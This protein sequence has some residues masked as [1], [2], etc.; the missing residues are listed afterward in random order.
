MVTSCR[1]IWP[2][3]VTSSAAVRA[4]TTNHRAGRVKKDETMGHR[5]ISDP[6]ARPIEVH[7]GRTH[8]LKEADPEER[9]GRPAVLTGVVLQMDP[10]LGP[11]LEP[12]QVAEALAGHASRKH[13]AC[14]PS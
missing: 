10:P 13:P 7:R 3:C 4:Q 9:R 6:A 14:P 11:L 8:R 2:I 12:T 1:T 5:E